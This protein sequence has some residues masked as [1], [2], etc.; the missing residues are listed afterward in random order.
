MLTIGRMAKKFNLSRSTLLYYDR[1][2]LLKPT[3]R[4]DADYR[5]YSRADTRRLEQIC[6]YRQAGLSL[7]DIADILD[8]PE[9]NLTRVMENRL[10]E[11]NEDIVRL[12]RQ[13]QFILHF[14][15]NSRMEGEIGLM[16]RKLWVELLRASG[17][18]DEDMSNWHKEFERL[19][20]EKHQE[21]LEFLCI[22]EEDIRSI[23]G[24]A[25]AG[26]DS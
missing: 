6:L 9:N 12:R 23:R 11:L 21:F 22:S 8:S 7:K 4:S 24:W 2:G 13:Q 14:L 19:H 20:P 10:L 15:K 3:G 1:L 25:G 17:F 26:P 16:N 5:L 18:S